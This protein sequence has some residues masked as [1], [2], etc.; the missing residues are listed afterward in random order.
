M[1]S[2]F[3]HEE[4]YEHNKISH[5]QRHFILSWVEFGSNLILTYSRW[6]INFLRK[7]YKI[8]LALVKEFFMY[9]HSLLSDCICFFFF[10]KYKHICIEFKCFKKITLFIFYWSIELYVWMENLM[11][12][13][14][15]F[16][17]KEPNVCVYV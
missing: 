15:F 5:F 7:C 13:F 9:M 16:G 11:I 3:I 17:C 8:S 1:K 6:Y 4:V 2:E 12:F 14:F 10:I